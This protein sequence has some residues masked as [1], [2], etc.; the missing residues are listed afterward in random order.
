MLPVEFAPTSSAGE[1]PQIY[2]LDRAATGTGKVF[3]YLF[4]SCFQ[5]LCIC[6]ETSF[7]YVRHYSFVHKEVKL[8][9][10][11]NYLL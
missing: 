2:A 8:L 9:Y 4:H 10:F 7:Y 11:S 1:L 5:L 3:Y 6:T